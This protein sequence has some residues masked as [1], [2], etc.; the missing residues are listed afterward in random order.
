[1]KTRILLIAT[2]ICFLFGSCEY[3]NFD[4][5]A[6]TLSGRVVYEGNP[7]GVRSTGTELEL[8]Q[9]GYQLYTKIPVYIAQDGTFSASLFNGTYKL[10]RLGGAPWEAQPSDTL[11]INVKGN[12]VIDVPVT[13]YFIIKNESFQKGEEGTF[14]VKFTIEK[15]VV[16]AEVQSINLYLGKNI[17]T[18]HNKNENSDGNDKYKRQFDLSKLVLGQEMTMT[19]IIPESL[20]KEGFCFARIGVKSNKSN[21]YLYTLVQKISFK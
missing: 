10:V 17:L 1:M 20:L 15:I 12:T 3:D 13:P 18:D 2:F 14:V 7:V 8:W 6:A 5:P 11:T 16:S 21:E 4:A 19:S 9:T